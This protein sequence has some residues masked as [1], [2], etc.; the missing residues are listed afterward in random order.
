M[1]VIGEDLVIPFTVG[2]GEGSLGAGLP[3]TSQ[4]VD[5]SIN[6]EVLDGVW[7]CFGVDRAVE[8][9][10]ETVSYEGNE[11]GPL[12]ASFV[13]KRNGWAAWPDLSPFTPVEIWVGGVLCWEGRTNGT[14]LKLGAETQ[15]SVQCEG[16]QMHLDDDLYKRLYVHSALTD[17]KDARSFVETQLAHYQAGP[18]VQAETG[19]IVLSLPKGCF[20]QSSEP[21]TYFGV[22]LDLGEAAAKQVVFT[23]GENTFLGGAD[24][25]LYCRGAQ[26]VGDFQEGPFEEGLVDFTVEGASGTHTA[27]FTEPQRYVQIFIFQ[28]EGEGETPAD[29]ALKITAISVFREEAYESAG[30]SVLKAS[31]VIENALAEATKLLSSDLSQIDTAADEFDIP[32]LVMA[33]YKTPRQQIEACNSFHNWLTQIDLERRMVFAPPSTEPLLEWGSW[34]GEG[35][36][37]LSAGEGSEIYNRVLV[38][39]VEPNSDPVD[40][41]VT[42]EEVGA[43][44][45]VDQ[46]GFRRSKAISLSNATNPTVAKEI[47]TVWLDDQVIIPFSG[48]VKA[49]VGSLRTVLGGQPVHPSQVCR[50]VNELLRISNAINPSDGSV[51]RD[52]RIVSCTYSHAEQAGEFTLGARTS[53]LEALLSRLAVIQEVGT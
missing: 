35:L 10:P 17:W 15:I 40:V 36:E 4:T 7:E 33:N 28:H 31:T 9:R 3:V 18:Q 49:N 21:H 30:S 8:V 27:T 37:D 26:S 38:E 44:T 43:T 1:P 45:V 13:L 46:R 32:T 42:A 41:S 25:K 50:H 24:H 23:L 14:P 48:S 11:W 22:I 39:G 19:A 47:G 20:V 53:S 5:V 29:E 52:G 16:W 6:A 34:S 12:K 2:E 51:G